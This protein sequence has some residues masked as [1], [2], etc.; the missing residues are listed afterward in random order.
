MAVMNDHQIENIIKNEPGFKKKKFKFIIARINDFIR[1]GWTS[2][3][4]IKRLKPF[5]IDFKKFKLVVKSFK[6]TGKKFD[7]NSL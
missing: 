2:I 3:K 4:P 1:E 5:L 6:L 7:W